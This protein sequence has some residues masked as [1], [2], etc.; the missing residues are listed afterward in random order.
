MGVPKSGFIVRGETKNYEVRGSS[1]FKSARHFCP[2]CG[3]LLFAMAEVAPQAI[4]I[5]AGSLDEPSIFH[6]DT[7]LFRRE[8][9]HWDITAGA[10][11]EFETMPPATTASK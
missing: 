8:R 6:P 4:S 11:S 1:G 9:H 10:L 3:S 5:Y 2:T 7:I